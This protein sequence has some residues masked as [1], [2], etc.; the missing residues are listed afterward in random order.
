M[1]TIRS[2]RLFVACTSILIYGQA[3][4]APSPELVRILNVEST[5]SACHETPAT[6]ELADNQS[7]VFTISALNAIS[8]NS[9]SPRDS[10]KNCLVLVDL[11]Y[12]EEWQY[13]LQTAEVKGN[14]SLADG[15]EGKNKISGHF[16]GY[17]V[18]SISDLTMAGPLASDYNEQVDFQP[19]SWSP[20]GRKRH[21]VI[22]FQSR[23][24]KS[25]ESTSFIESDSETKVIINW[26]KCNE[27]E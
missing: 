22:S 18:D 19:I 27:D 7:L 26:R 1:K 21:L 24:S 11:E 2:H 12:P 16:Q 9:T 23:V 20:C 15:I 14:V 8:S 13:S 5:G 4:G 17:S 3:L 10:R 25:E 6:A